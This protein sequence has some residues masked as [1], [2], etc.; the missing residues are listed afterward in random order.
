MTPRKTK[1]T[2][3]YPR[4]HLGQV[5]TANGIDGGSWITGREARLL[6]G[7]RTDVLARWEGEGVISVSQDGP[8]SPRLYLR[9]EMEVVAGLRADA[10]PT[11]REVRR[12]LA[13][14]EAQRTPGSPQ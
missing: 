5:A 9:P 11:L 2:P 1:P 7:V 12:H 14:R 3:G 8:G 6:T 4:T 13:Q 10:P